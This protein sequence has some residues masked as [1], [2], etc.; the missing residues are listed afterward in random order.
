M[1]HSLGGM[2]FYAT[3]FYVLSRESEVKE[4]VKIEIKDVSTFSNESSWLGQI[5][6]ESGSS[7]V[8]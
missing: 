7:L 6:T 3:L 4:K 5:K 2:G 8:G 1:T